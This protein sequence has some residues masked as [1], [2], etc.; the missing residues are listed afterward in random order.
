MNPMNDDCNTKIA[1][2][3]PSS[4][5]SASSLLNSLLILWAA[6]GEL[7]TLRKTLFCRTCCW[8]SRI[9][10]GTPYLWRMKLSGYQSFPQHAMRSPQ[11]NS[12]GSFRTSII[13]CR[14]VHF[15]FS[16]GVF[17]SGS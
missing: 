3:K 6:C 17:T 8:G 5:S 14:S 13:L 1:D 12:L 4:S 2:E 11:Q 16:R 10:G 9:V 15:T 7:L